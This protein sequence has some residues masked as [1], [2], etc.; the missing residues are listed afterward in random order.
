MP[1]SVLVA[2]LGGVAADYAIAAFIIKTVVSFAVS[3][4]LGKKP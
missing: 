3:S 4:D 2:V 1:T